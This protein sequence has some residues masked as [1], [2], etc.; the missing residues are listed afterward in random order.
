[1]IEVS[2]GSTGTESGPGNG[3]G[4]FPGGTKMK[5]V[6]RAMKGIHLLSK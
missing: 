4:G 2:L 6:E 5:V 3:V 1:M